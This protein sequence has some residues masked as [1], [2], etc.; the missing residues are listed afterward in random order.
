[1]VLAR[2]VDRRTALDLI[3]TY[4]NLGMLYVFDFPSADSLWIS[5][6][7][8][9]AQHVSD[10]LAL[11]DPL[12]GV[13]VVLD[14]CD[15]FADWSAT[16][17]MAGMVNRLS[18][19]WGPKPPDA[20]QPRTV[21]TDDASIATF[22]TMDDSLSTDL[23]G[24][25]DAQYL[26]DAR[27]AALA[28][29][30]PSFPDLRADLWLTVPRSSGAGVLYCNPTSLLGLTNLPPGIPINA[31]GLVVVNGYT[32]TISPDS[33]AF[34]FAVYDPIHSATRKLWNLAPDTASWDAAPA[35]IGWDTVDDWDW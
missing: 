6:D 13:N 14:A 35:D 24:L 33:W 20:E 19:G 15:L 11:P 27:F 30:S 1:M 21:F 17:S 5:Q 28:A 12:D 16:W 34:T 4:A 26:A 29:P 7:L 9:L 8:E 2:D 10:V 23:V 32:E 22:A 18:I 25:V 3:T 31:A